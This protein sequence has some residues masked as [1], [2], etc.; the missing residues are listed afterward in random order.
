MAPLLFP[1]HVKGTRAELKNSPVLPSLKGD[2]TRAPLTREEPN[3]RRDKM[4]FSAGKIVGTT[5]KVV[6]TEALCQDVPA[7]HIGGW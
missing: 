5:G 6:P 2:P 1:A 7:L 3:E 4:L